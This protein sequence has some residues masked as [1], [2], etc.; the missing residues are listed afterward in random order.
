DTTG[1][2]KLHHQIVD[3]LYGQLST[4]GQVVHIQLYRLSWGRGRPNCFISLPKLARR[5]NLS[6][7]SAGEAVA[8]LESKGLIRKGSVVIGRGKEQGIEYW[9]APA[10]AF[11][12][13]AS[14]ANPASLAT[15][16]SL[17]K[18]SSRIEYKEELHEEHTHKEPCVSVSSRFSP[19]ECRRYA[20]HLQRTG[21]GITNPGGYA[22]TIHRTGQADT[23]IRLCRSQ[24]LPQSDISKCPDCKGQGFKVFERD[25]REGVVKCRHEQVESRKCLG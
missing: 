5:C 21:Q 18:S 24:Q 8:L 10:P 1:F 12:K 17:A 16:A 22:T 13:T 2:T 19:K 3:H 15:S 9:I 25:G 20:E 6:Q 7:R 4:K 14:L 23:L 11:A